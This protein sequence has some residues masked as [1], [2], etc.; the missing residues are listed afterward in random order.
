MAARLYDVTDLERRDCRASVE[1]S[2][3]TDR[4]VSDYEALVRRL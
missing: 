1:Q 4:M 2:F 3:S